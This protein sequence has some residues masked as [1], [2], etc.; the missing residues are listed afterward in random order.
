MKRKDRWLSAVL[1]CLLAAAP[2]ADAQSSQ[3]GAWHYVLE[4]YFMLANLHGTAGLGTL[5]DAAVDESPSDIFSHLQMGAMLYAEA[6]NDAWS[7]SSDVLYMNLAGNADANRVIAYGRVDLKQIGWELALLHRLTDHIDVGIGAQLNSVDAGL[8]LAINVPI[9]GVVTNDFDQKHTWVDPTILLRGTFPLTDKWSISGRGNVGGFDVASK[10]AWQV[11]LYAQ[12][13]F[14]PNKYF[15]FGYR[16]IGDDYES[17]SGSSRFL[18]DIT[19][20]GPVARIAF[21][22]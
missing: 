5:P 9:I 20:F 19:T 22:F 14:S 16:V 2:A 13:H 15:S 6:S 4:P 18:Y 17:G 11:Q 3:D 8:H 12:Y 1:L 21:T 7:I 10:F